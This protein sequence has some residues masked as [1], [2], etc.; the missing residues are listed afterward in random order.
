MRR[1]AVVL[2]GLWGGVA[3]A[4]DVGGPDA[5][6]TCTVGLARDETG[7]IY[8]V[9]GGGDHGLVRT[10]VRRGGV[11]RRSAPRVALPWTPS[12]A[13]P[14]PTQGGA[15]VMRLVRTPGDF[16]ALSVRFR[17]GSTPLTDFEGRPADAVS[18]LDV[19]AAGWVPVA[20]EARPVAFVSVLEP[21]AYCCSHTLFARW[22][23]DRRWHW[24]AHR[25]GNYRDVPA[26]D[27]ADR[28]GVVEW[29]ARDPDFGAPW[30][31]VTGG[32]APLGVWHLGPRG[33]DAVTWR[34]RA[35]LEDD[36]RWLASVPD[37][38]F[39]LASWAAEARLLGRP[40][41]DGAL[42]ARA[43]RIGAGEGMNL[44]VAEWTRRIRGLADR[45][46]ATHTRAR[47]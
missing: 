20:G 43:T 16:D 1:V 12:E 47:P 6:R 26:L 28:D 37:S 9:A 15:N 42:R 31:H 32:F 24:S 29:I 33:F 40:V 41:P 34:F 19:V 39:A 25:W 36:L 44:S 14:A 2:W 13:T 3:L 4:Q 18:V 45:Y 5:A 10:R 21:G 27:D 17:E 23:G 11:W 22:G 8:E 38:D 30:P 35:L 7:V 46:V